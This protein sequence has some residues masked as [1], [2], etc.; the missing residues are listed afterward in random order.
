MPLEGVLGKQSGDFGAEQMYFT[1]K[2]NN[3]NKIAAP[4]I[5][6]VRRRLAG[7]LDVFPQGGDM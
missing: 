5:G 2:F 1:L 7:V 4:F 6:Q 3:R